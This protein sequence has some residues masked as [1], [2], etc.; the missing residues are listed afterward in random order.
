MRR[1]V[2][3]STVVVACI[4]SVVCS[5]AALTA[6]AE[7]DDIVIPQPF[8]PRAEV[9]DL[10]PGPLLPHRKLPPKA[11][12]TP[13][14]AIEQT[15]EQCVEADMRALGAPGAAVTV[16]LDGEVIFDRGFGYRL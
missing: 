6:S 5:V 10:G 7:N 3:L 13:A 1:V 2:W 8:N 14:Y 11:E 16:R 9:L 12:A 4:L 15:I